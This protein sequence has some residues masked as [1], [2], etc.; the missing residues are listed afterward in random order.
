M[1][2]A[3]HRRAFVAASVGSVLSVMSG[4]RYK[5]WGGLGGV[6]CVAGLLG[7]TLRGQMEC[8]FNIRCLI[9]VR[10]GSCSMPVAYA[11][12]GVGYGGGEAM[13]SRRLPMVWRPMC[14]CGIVRC[15]AACCEWCAARKAVRSPCGGAGRNESESSWSGIER[16]KL[17]QAVEWV[18]ARVGIGRSGPE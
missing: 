9:G 15:G 3:R 12:G 16:N 2:C 14:G 1:C 17:E 7:C 8:L 4:V 6:L 18:G 5:Q 13:W 11:R 10:W